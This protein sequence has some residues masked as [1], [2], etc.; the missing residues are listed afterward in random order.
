MKSIST[1]GSTVAP[2]ILVLEGLGFA[3]SVER[4]GG[5]DLVRAVRGD[6]TYIA[7]DP[8]TV[9][10][11]V[12]LVEL[13]GWDWRAADSDLDRVTRQYQLS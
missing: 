4:V 6:E 7:D 12:K 5:E 1:A 3:I 9:L 10:G 2:A 8:V 13:R 11:L